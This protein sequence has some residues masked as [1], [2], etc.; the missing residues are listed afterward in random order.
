M[1]AFRYKQSNCDHT[2][3]L[4]CQNG[5]LRTLIVY[6]DGMVVTGNDPDER[7]A[8][9]KYL[10]TEV[11]DEGSWVSENIFS[12]LRYQGVSQESSCHRESIFLTC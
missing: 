3:F 11:R 4:K 1:R 10:S 8:L 2:L 6:V 5:K 7:A 9:Q 12:G